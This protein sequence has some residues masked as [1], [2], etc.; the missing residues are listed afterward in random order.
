MD[1][2]KAMRGRQIRERGQKHTVYKG[3]ACQ[4]SSLSPA[5]KM[6]EEG[7]ERAPVFRPLQAGVHRLQQS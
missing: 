3:G 6:P 1:Y 2:F 7:Q 4:S 5:G